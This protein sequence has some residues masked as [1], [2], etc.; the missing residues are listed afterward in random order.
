MAATLTS[1]RHYDF[2]IVGAGILG[3]TSAY[4][5]KKRLPAA[6][7]AILEKEPRP[8]MHA[9]GRNSGVLH[10]GIYYASDT[11]KARV[12]ATG[13]ARMR[14]FA[15][16][17]AIPCNRSGK[18]IIATSAQDIPTVERLLKN[19][20]DNHIRAER[21]DEQGIKAIEPHANPYQVG[22]YSP[23]TAVIDS[24]A[25]LEKLRGLLEDAGVRFYFN[26]E[27]VAI[28]PETK[29]VVTRENRFNYGYLFNC[30]GASADIV[31]RKFGLARDYALLPFKGLYYKL[32]PRKDYLVKNSIYPVPDIGLPFLG[33]HLT[34]VISGEVYVGP[35]AIPAFGRENYGV[36]AGIKPLEGLQIG[37]R[38]AAM[39]ARN[40][41]NFRALVHHELG[42]YFKSGF[43][44]AT[45]KLV[46]EVKSEYLLPCEKVG[47]RPQ[48]VNLRKQQLEMDYIIEQTPSSLHVLNAISP[49]FTSSFAFAEML[50]DR[51]LMEKAA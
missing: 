28:S 18:V 8:G 16:E 13:A 48:L 12:C 6:T 44:A 10:S 46:P 3:L 39:Y 32:D 25:V 51:C 26:Q 21:L 40:Q 35:T 37:W 27:A 15:A 30:A 4:E 50:V 20:R 22:I 14:E 33:V 2:I 19:A 23:D 24:S 45:Q 36:L 38:M 5:L 43:L 11:L 29:L 47:I 34:R 49:A 7:I 42:K 31:A 1:A 17:H 9:S 41:Q